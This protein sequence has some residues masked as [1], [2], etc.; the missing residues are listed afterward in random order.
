MPSSFGAG[1]AYVFAASPQPGYR[2][3]GIRRG[4]DH[5]PG[6]PLGTAM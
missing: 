3:A 5:F 4:H 6:W 2:P 1:S